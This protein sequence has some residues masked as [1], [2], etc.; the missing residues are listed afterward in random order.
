MSTTERTGHPTCTVGAC[1]HEGNESIT[2]LAPL[3]EIV[4]QI[5][6]A[7]CMCHNQA[8]AKRSRVAR[9]FACEQSEAR[10]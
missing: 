3:G 7:V 1:R 4:S 10:A 8:T 6:D 9:R 2:H 5:G